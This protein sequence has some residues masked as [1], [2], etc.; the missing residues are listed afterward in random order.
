MSTLHEGLAQEGDSPLKVHRRMPRQNKHF[1]TLTQISFARDP[2]QDRTAMRLTTLDRP[3]L[4]SEIGQAF[5]ACGI[6]L[7]HAKITTLGAEVEDIFFIA[8]INNHPLTDQNQLECLRKAVN[9]RLPE[10]EDEAY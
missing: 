8:D 3:G 5:E 7:Q 4:L 6:R 9:D 1:K 2:S 10:E